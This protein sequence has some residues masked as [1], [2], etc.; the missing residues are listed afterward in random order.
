LVK[1]AT[2]AGHQKHIATQT[3]PVIVG[4]I[5][6]RKLL[7]G[8][9]VPRAPQAEGGQ[10]TG[11]GI[12]QR[13]DGGQVEGIQQGV[14]PHIICIPVRPEKAGS[15]VVGLKGPRGIPISVGAEPGARG[16]QLRGEE[17]QAP[18]PNQQLRPF[19]IKSI[20]CHIALVIWLIAA[21]ISSFSSSLS[22]SS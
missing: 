3:A 21:K 1:P 16:A 18:P 9:H 11:H 13:G 14:F 20:F 8:A 5:N 15:P 2:I 17:I 10:Q 22:V 7:V 12:Y 4:V 19:E 6:I